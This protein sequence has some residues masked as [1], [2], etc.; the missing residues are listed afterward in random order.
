MEISFKKDI[1][2]NKKNFFSNI[3]N[4]LIK[5]FKNSNSLFYYF[6][7]LCGL[8]FLFFI[9]ILLV[10]YFTTPFSGDYCAQQF[11]FYLNGYDDWWHFL[12]TGEFVFYDT[13]TYLGVN[14]IG[15]NSFY[16][17]FNP[18]FVPILL[19]PRSLVPQGM[20]FLTIIKL[21]LAGLFFYFYMSY[22]K[23]KDS[24]ARICGVMYAFCGWTCWYLWFNHFSEVATIFPLILL[25][26]E[27]VLQEKK[28]FLLSFALFLMGITNYFF[29]ICFS[30]C[31][32]FYAIFRYFQRFKLNKVNDNLI[33][34]GL[35]F[36]AFLAGLLLSMVVVLPSAL[37][38]IHSDRATSSTYLK[39]LI[40]AFKNNELSDAFGLLFSWKKVD[41]EKGYRIYYPLIEFFFPTM[42][43]RGTPLTVLGNESYD[44]V[45]GSLF[46]FS[47]CIIYFL[48]ALINSFKDK[49]VSHFIALLCFL[50]MIISPFFYYLYFGFTKPYSRWYLFV[51]T[52]LIA[53]IGFY[54]DKIKIE[55]KYILLSGFIFA[56]LGG[57]L[58]FNFAKILIS[59]FD[60]FS[61]RV[62]LV[63]ALI[64]YIIYICISAIGVFYYRNKKQF[65]KL[66]LSFVSFEIILMGALTINLHGYNE[67]TSV[68]NGL[69][70]NN[71]LYSLTNK[72][73]KNDKS[74]FRAYSSLA[75]D[76]ARNDGMRN[77]YN[78]V[79]FFH[80]LYNFNLA[81]FLSWSRLT[82]NY[83]GWS[84]S[85]VEKRINLDTF[86]GIKYYFVEKDSYKGL[87]PNIPLGYKDISSIYENSKFKVYKNEHYIDLGFS[88]DNITFY[89]S[90]DG[91]SRPE[92]D[93]YSS[94]SYV[95]RNEQLYLQTGL[96]N[97]K[98]G[99]E[100]LNNYN[101]EKKEILSINDKE[102][103]NFK[104]LS[105]N[106]DSKSNPNKANT[107]YDVEYYY[108]DGTDYYSLSLDELNEVDKNYTKVDRPINHPE[109]NGKY[110]IFIKPN[111][112]NRNEFIHDDNHGD[113]FYLDSSFSKDN[114]MDI[115]LRNKEGKL[116]KFDNFND[117]KTTS[118]SKSMRGI[119]VYPDENLSSIIIVPR[120]K[121]IGNINLYYESGSTYFS[122]IDELN[123]NPLENVKYKT[124]H[125]DFTTNFN[126]ERMIV[127]RLAY[128]DGWKATLIDEFNNKSNA[129]IYICNGGFVGFMCPKGK[130]N[131]QLDFYP[132]FYS[133]GS[134][135]SATGLFIY[136][137]LYLSYLYLNLEFLNKNKAKQ[138]LFF[139]F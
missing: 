69:D 32:F 54:L 87:Q 14:N 53:Y 82:Q 94:G 24:H 71:A 103:L 7:L 81:P 119:Y 57:V 130:Y 93:L 49:K 85:Y 137:S 26:I 18:F 46:C 106:F 38:A 124:N 73:N 29:L 58:S 50:I 39:D 13:N 30:I 59:K 131:I 133:L 10:N 21:A 125:F 91:N 123:K 52:S 60:N 47:P 36:I 105:L 45:A 128:E 62:N 118:N 3:K 64:L 121:K 65:E 16:Y 100:I 109:K 111:T 2:L 72:I 9:S 12:K 122:L 135:L 68:N 67:F 22:F 43:D 1:K 138:T 76:N 97:Y 56:I 19:F 40:N 34:L 77:S 80:S 90:I 126:S 63:L 132:P 114:K 42:S 35:G 136:F 15:S 48:P 108:L 20:A 112:N 11:S 31:A 86:L 79:S 95:L 25:G 98:D 17:L 23:I 44:N 70:K 88:Y 115:Y 120:Y 4:Y 116:F 8:G 6:L 55:N 92:G 139:N 27:H 51:I 5:T 113:I 89:N 96:V 134:Y 28:P 66:M 37:V 84:G 78:G 41:G 117:P 107:L 127:T 110:V 83:N 74:Y 129:K 102:N 33:I 104:S 101:I 99:G 61:E 75:N